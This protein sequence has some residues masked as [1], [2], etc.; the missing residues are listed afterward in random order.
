MS[1]KKILFVSHEASRTGAPIV[2]LNFLKW[3]KQHS[4]IPFVILLKAGGE[5]TPEFEALAPTY[6]YPF[7]YRVL[8]GIRGKIMGN[9]NTYVAMPNHY[10]KLKKD[11]EAHSIGLVYLNAVAS[12]SLLHFLAFL[13]CKVVTHV[14]ELA[15][16]F[17]FN[18]PETIQL[19][20]RYTHRYI[21]V[22][23]AVKQ[24]L[25]QQHGVD[26]QQIEVV[27]EF[28]P[29]ADLPGGD[30]S[31]V[32]AA[33]NVPE[34]AFV[35]GASGTMD[36]RKGFDLLVPLAQ[37]VH[38]RMPGKPFYFVWIGGNPGDP[39]YFVVKS[40]AEKTG[41]HE[42]IRVPGATE[43]P[44][45]YFS[46]FDVMVLLSREDPFPLVCL[47][48]SLLG[49][50]TICFDKAGGMPELVAP[51]CGFVVPYLDV[52]AMAEKI[53]Y[54]YNHPQTGKEL[55][56]NAREKVLAR[57][58]VQTTAPTLLNLLRGMGI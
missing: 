44:M 22:S 54:L 24:N 32:S 47:E 18:G 51:D 2:L 13:N 42:F 15:L 37:A 31:Q 10:R 1:R 49:K 48:T 55:G 46:R 8:S 11:L 45:T 40:D 25:V 12:G 23:Q 27:Y 7:P 29:N 4:D 50:P 39:F 5:L 43:K 52:K 9:W 14:H 56:R 38:R 6:L 58:S 30:R 16:G 20:T 53:I 21:A 17:Y 19:L 33:L 57:H 34:N 41:M 35:V 26:A 28:I 36:L 3:M